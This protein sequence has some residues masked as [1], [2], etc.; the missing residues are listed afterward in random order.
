MPKGPAPQW[1]KRKEPI[2][3]EHL[4]ASIEAVES[5]NP[6]NGFYGTL[7]YTG[8]KDEA[9]AKEIKQALYRSANHFG[10]SLK[11]EII[12]DE[13][14]GE[15]SVVYTAINKTYGRK[16]ILET[17][18]KDRAKWPYDPRQPNR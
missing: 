15:F 14:T 4:R 16:Y 13:K 6:E 11:T 10:V 7:V 9:R 17:F 18:G 8:C 2:M 12:Q 5:C 1:R 3:D